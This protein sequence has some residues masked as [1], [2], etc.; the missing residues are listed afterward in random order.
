M[1]A[2]PAQADLAEVL[3]L[4][5]VISNPSTKHL[6]TEQQWRWRIFNRSHNGLSE[7]RAIVKRSGRWY[8]VLPRLRDWL[9]NAEWD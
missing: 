5:D 9:L 7:S 3:P 6:G 8:V 4:A 1:S 2:A